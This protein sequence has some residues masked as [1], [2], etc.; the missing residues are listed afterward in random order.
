MRVNE[1]VTGALAGNRGPQKFQCARR[2]SA[3][4]GFE[5][6]G[7]AVALSLLSFIADSDRGSRRSLPHRGAWLPGRAHVVE[8]AGDGRHGNAVWRGVAKSAEPEMRERMARSLATERGG[9]RQR[10]GG[11]V[12][13]R[14]GPNALTHDP[15]ALTQDLT[16]TH[17]A[18]DGI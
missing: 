16:R 13:A 10:E 15:N 8:R 1:L 2:S 5:R 18:Q 4:A 9:M 14:P 12:N 17:Y 11:C 3:S 6:Y 7:N